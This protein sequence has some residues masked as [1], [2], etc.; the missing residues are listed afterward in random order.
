M[1]IV[2]IKGIETPTNIT[3]IGEARDSDI[4]IEAYRTPP[5]NKNVVLAYKGDYNS[6][7]YNEISKYDWDIQLIYAV[8]MAESHLKIDEI[9]PDDKHKTCMGSYG[10]PQLSCEH[11]YTYDIW[12]SWQD[13][14][15]VIAVA[16]KVYKRQG[17]TA[18]GAYT[19]GSYLKYL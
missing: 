2:A 13:P 18:W 17:I 19:D 9:N 10:I 12:D 14:E 11:L 3:N 8:F 7:I 4:F 16:Y 15:V 5:I 6:V 1:G